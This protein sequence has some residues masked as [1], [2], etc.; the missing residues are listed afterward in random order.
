V[1][2]KDLQA[3][4]ALKLAKEILFFFMVIAFFP[5]VMMF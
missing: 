4:R 2:I 5:L 1:V 3:N